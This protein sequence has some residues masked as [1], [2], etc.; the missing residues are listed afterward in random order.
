MG[1]A[2]WRRSSSFFT[3]IKRS[4]GSSGLQ[5]GNGTGIGARVPWEVYKIRGEREVG[6]CWV[7]NVDSQTKEY[8]GNRYWK[9]WRV[10]LSTD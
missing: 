5:K 7:N 9:E 6:G 8:L 2:I 3:G 1:K 4:R 10:V